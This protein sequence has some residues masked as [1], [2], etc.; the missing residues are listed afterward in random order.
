MGK[1]LYVIIT[2]GRQADSPIQAETVQQA[3]LQKLMYSGPIPASGAETAAYLQPFNSERRVCTSPP[4]YAGALDSRPLQPYNALNPQNQ[5]S[6]QLSI[7]VGGSPN[8]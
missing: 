7:V 1:T 3:T 8:L 6:R 5:P 4:I 2:Q